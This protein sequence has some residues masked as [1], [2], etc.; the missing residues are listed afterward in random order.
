MVHRRIKYSGD[1]KD[2]SVFISNHGNVLFNAEG[3]FDLSGVMYCPRYSVEFTLSGQGTISLRGVCRKI[4]I[5]NMTG[6]CLLDLT[7]VV[8]SE[9]YCKLAKDKSIILIGTTK[10][11]SQVNLVG[12]SILQYKGRPLIINSSLKESSRMEPFMKMK[13]RILEIA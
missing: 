7:D 5:K 8:C 1:Q 3:K 13:E 4:I 6:D 10:L 12:E 2:D 11:I 9:V